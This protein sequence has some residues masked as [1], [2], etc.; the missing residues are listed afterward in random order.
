MTRPA[1]L[2][3]GLLA[4][5]GEAFPAGGFAAAGIGLSQPLPSPH[6]RPRSCRPQAS[7]AIGGVALPPTAPEIARH[8]RV[9]LTVRLD[10]VRHARLRIFSA[11][12][13]RTC[14][15][16]VIEALDAYLQACGPDCACM[17]HERSG[18][19]RS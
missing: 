5:K 17:R 9:A 2:S 16:V 12:R 6:A 3:S 18:S 4:R 14:Q 15:D 10:P 1:R 19:G 13:R 7:S 8:E 11:R